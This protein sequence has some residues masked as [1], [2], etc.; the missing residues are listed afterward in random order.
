MTIERAFGRL[1]SRWRFIKLHL[2]MIDLKD[3]TKV[4]TAA[5]IL[6]NFCIDM[7]DDNFPEEDDDLDD[8]DLDLESSTEQEY[9][10]GMTR[11][12]QLRQLFT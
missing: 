6:H 12:E 11:R 1:A 3:I 7:Q 4:I 8:G 10:L 2:Y 9:R 5:C